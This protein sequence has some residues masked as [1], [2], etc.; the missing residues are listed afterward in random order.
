M[1]KRKGFGIGN[2][3]KREEEYIAHHITLEALLNL[4][5]EEA[6]KWIASRFSI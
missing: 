3:T 1:N 6:F 2:Q 4:T 5:T